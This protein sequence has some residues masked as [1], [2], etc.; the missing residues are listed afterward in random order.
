[1]NNSS[2]NGSN[3]VKNDI[4]RDLAYN[5][6]EV[7]KRK[8]V[9][10]CIV[11]RDV[12]KMSQTISHIANYK[13]YTEYKNIPNIGDT[14]KAIVKLLIFAEKYSNNKITTID[15]DTMMVK[16]E[17]KR[18]LD[19]LIQKKRDGDETIDNE[20]KTKL[21]MIDKIEKENN[22]DGYIN[23]LTGSQIASIAKKV[24]NI[25]KKNG[26]GSKILY[27][28]FVLL[29][30]PVY[31][32][33]KESTG[34]DYELK[35][36][37]RD[38]R[39]SA[40]NNNKWRTK[41]ATSKINSNDNMQYSTKSKYTTPSEYKE[42]EHTGISTKYVPPQIL[43]NTKTSVDNT[44]SKKYTPP[45]PQSNM[46]NSNTEPS[47]ISNTTYGY[48]PPHIRQNMNNS[49][50]EINKYSEHESNKDTNNSTYISINDIKDTLD[51]NSMELF[52]S[53]C[54]KHVNT[55]S[56]TTLHFFENVSENSFNVLDDWEN[57][58]TEETVIPTKNPQ[59]VVKPGWGGKSFVKVLEE[60]K[61][62]QLQ[63]TE[64]EPEPEKQKKNI[65]IPTFKPKSTKTP[66][67]KISDEDDITDDDD[68]DIYNDWGE[69]GIET[70]YY[71]NNNDDSDW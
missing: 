14:I 43:P 38:R 39:Y 46:N 61:Q 28:E 34:G 67:T 52:P 2:K 64:T 53:L 45:L 40:D 17:L 50:E 24:F 19:E 48:I 58:D 71:E 11:P 22:T 49:Q 4:Y 25:M 15:S 62:K 32:Y 41:S 13:L 9:T 3:V 18:Q 36:S 51:T 60:A 31:N 54:K 27:N 63:K 33:E 7:Y 56:N 55:K 30:K 8:D 20:I 69:D 21:S 12:R 35:N 10:K 59:I 29:T 66:I 16:T 1:M 5:F 6:S 37:T 44:T 65:S 42:N 68:D 26:Q 57:S 70:E 47:M 23:K